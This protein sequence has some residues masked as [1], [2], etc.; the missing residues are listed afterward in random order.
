MNSV[1]AILPAV[2]R[3]FELA[4]AEAMTDTLPVPIA[5]IMDPA[6]APAAFLPF[7]AAHESVDLWFDDWSLARKRQMIGEALELAALKGTR[8]GLV[9]FLGFV[10]AEVTWLIAHPARFSVGRSAIGV[11]PIAHRPMTAHYLV[12]VPL[13]APANPFRIGRA[14]L[15]RQ[16]LTRVS[17]E[18]LQRARMATV[19]AKA[20]ETLTSLNFAWRRRARFGDGLPLD[21]SIR[22]GQFVDRP[23]L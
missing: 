18:P 9:R 6:T 1:R 16:A 17:L 12:K 22:F 23:R 10:D 7:L 3:P 5:A 15:G 21:G 14:A 13:S 4:A 2:A 19:I 20:P 11:R 8:E